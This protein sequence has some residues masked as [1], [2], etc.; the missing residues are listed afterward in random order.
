MTS[1][2]LHKAVDSIHPLTQIS[3]QNGW[4]ECVGNGDG[5][6]GT[7]GPEKWVVSAAVMHTKTSPLSLPQY[8]FPDPWTI[9]FIIVAKD[10]DNIAEKTCTSV[11][12]PRL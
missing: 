3:L 12:L 10:S 5:E 7:L 4:A 8:M 6:K 2:W 1:G 9:G 11:L